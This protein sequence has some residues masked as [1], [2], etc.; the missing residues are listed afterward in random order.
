MNVLDNNKI[1][2]G[3]VG[4]AS[5][6]VEPSSVRKEKRIK[7]ELK[8]NPEFL[9]AIELIKLRNRI[10]TTS[11]IIETIFN[12]KSFN[13]NSA[14][15]SISKSRSA[16]NG[17]CKQATALYDYCI[18]GAEDKGSIQQIQSLKKY[19]SFIE[20]DKKDK[21]KVTFYEA[22]KDVHKQLTQ[23]YRVG[24][25]FIPDESQDVLN[26][27][28]IFNKDIDEDLPPRRNVSFRLNASIDHIYFPSD[29]PKVGD[30]E[31][32]RVLHQALMKNC[33]FYIE[34]TTPETLEYVKVALNKFNKKIK[35]FNRQKKEGK[36]VDIHNLFLSILQLKKSLIE[37]RGK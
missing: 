1:N 31:F 6:D 37:Y 32:R 9:K 36:P 26:I 27:I 8:V 13:I 35:E 10:K 23:T 15:R 4:L 17:Y 21:A 11:E 18:A 25:E 22:L 19:L 33:E 16:F 2:Q 5:F 20:T 14:K 7:H 30:S 12:K 34:R 3:K 29:R 28:E 24:T